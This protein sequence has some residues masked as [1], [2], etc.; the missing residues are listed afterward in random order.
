L[1]RSGVVE[2]LRDDRFDR[3][4]FGLRAERPGRPFDPGERVLLEA[5]VPGGTTHVLACDTIE[6]LLAQGRQLQQRM[7][8]RSG[9]LR[10][11]PRWRRAWPRRLARRLA[12]WRSSGPSVE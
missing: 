1:P 12:A 9:A 10:G 6:G 7:G 8:A 11:G 4:G 3:T 2:F 5:A